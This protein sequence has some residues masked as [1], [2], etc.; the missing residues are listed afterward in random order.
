MRKFY[1]LFVAALLGSIGS[2]AATWYSQGTGDPNV[3]AN[4]NSLP[5]GGGAT[6]TSFTTAGDIW[7]MQTNMTSPNSSPWALSQTSTLNVNSVTW[8]IGGLNS[9]TVGNLNV[10]GTSY[11][12][13]TG[14]GTNNFYIYGDLTISGT[15]YMANPGGLNGYYLWLS[16]TASTVAS[17]Q[18]VSITTSNPGNVYI[19]LEVQPGVTAQ[20]AANLSFSGTGAWCY[21]NGT[22][23]CQNYTFGGNLGIS[24]NSGGMIYTANAG[25]LAAT[26]ITTGSKS[27]STS[28][29]YAF[30][31]TAAQVTSTMLPTALQT[32]SKLII[33]NPAGVTLSQS[34]TLNNTSAGL[35]LTNGILSTGTY[36]LTVPGN[37]AAVSGAGA[38]SYVKG[39]LLKPITGV[40]AVNYEVGDVNYAPMSLAFNVPGSAGSIAVKTTNGLHPQVATS[41]INSATIVNHYW[42]V[43][44]SGAAGPTTVTPTVTYNAADILGGSN[45]AF[46]TNRYTTSWLPVVMMNTN[47]STPYTSTPQSSISLSSLAGDYI[48][49]APVP[50]V[51]TS[52]PTMDFGLIGTGLSSTSQFF[53][54]TGLSLTTSSSVTITA[55]ANFQVSSDNATWVSSYSLPYTGTSISSVPVYVRF[56]P[57]A[58]TAYTGTVT[59]TGGGLASATNLVSLTGTGTTACSGVPA[60]GTASITPGAGGTSTPFTLSLAGA[61][62][63]GS[64]TY[65]WQ[66]SISA[67]SGFTNIAGATTSNYSFT[68]VGVST[69]YQALVTCPSYAAAISNT[70][71]ATFSMTATYLGVV[72]TYTVPAGVTSLRIQ[73]SGAQGGAMTSSFPASGGSGAIMQGDFCVAPGQVLAYIVGGQGATANYSGGGGGGSFVWDN[74]TGAP[75]I[76]A[77]GGGGA[78]YNSGAGA[79]VGMSASTGV[80]GTVSGAGVAYGGAGTAGSGGVVPSVVEYAAGGA[81]WLS[82]GAAG[83]QTVSCT[84]GNAVGGV[85]PLAGG[86]GGQMGKR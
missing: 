76:A 42:T 56:N 71:A 69:Y 35:T 51:F 13:A 64:I 83:V 33:N 30:N 75:L 45:A 18:H 49:G 41:N 77:G 57:T 27:F 6:P 54:L 11:C 3:F 73:A 26:F 61:T 2:F 10:T 32:S 23:D 82:N 50:T 22:L 1:L 46:V 53:N 62:T 14:A 47:T 34:T 44:N 58:A 55:S 85:K 38:N 8:S 72:G 31:G 19:Y 80:N 48:F 63:G 25:G 36:T 12:S 9:F 24:A 52:A 17:P 60:S 66:S 40:I 84:Y 65:Q 21:M 7:N 43:T 37:A 29:S 4:W 86:L 16:N 74:A 68:G 5:A 28:A 81:G 15:A 20:L 79:G 78:A 59:V 39:T 67:T 70:V